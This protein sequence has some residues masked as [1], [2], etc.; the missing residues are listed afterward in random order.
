MS[1]T[2]SIRL[3]PVGII[4]FVLQLSVA[5]SEDPCFNG[6]TLELE[7]LAKRSPSYAL[8]SAPLCD[9][10]ITEA[11]Y[12]TQGYV[13]TIS[14]PSLT[15]CGTLYPVW[16]SET[17]PPDGIMQT[18]T[19]CEVGFSGSCARSY[20]ID[21]KNCTSFLVYK[22]K[23]LDVCNSAYCFELDG[24]CINERVDN[25][26]VSFHNVTWKTTSLSGK[27]QHD[28]Y[29]NLNCSF[30][31]S[32][33]G[34]LL[35]HIDWYVD[36]DI[37]VRGQTVDRTSLQDAILSAEDMIN[38]G[39]KINSWIHCVVGIK[40][41]PHKNPCFSKPSELFFA[42]LEVLDGVLTIERNGKGT[43]R[44]RPT[45]PYASL[46][47]ETENGPFSL[48]LDISLFFPGEENCGA[49]DKIKFR[50]CKTTIDSY[51]YDQRNN[52]INPA[53]WRTIYTLDV[54]N[55]DEEAYYLSHQKS[56]LRL[57]T[58]D[59][60]GGAKIFA[61]ASLHDIE[62]TIVDRDSPWKGKHCHS[63]GD[64]HQLT[65]DGYGYECQARGCVTGKTYILYRNEEFIQEVQ[66][67]HE[68]CGTMPRC[69]CA[70]AARAGQDVFTIDFCNGREI[71]N[72]PLCNENS[73]KVIKLYDKEYKII[74]PSGTYMH[75]S[76]FHM[77][78]AVWYSAVEIYPSESDVSRTS[79]LCGSLDSNKTNDL[80]RRNGTEDNI[81]LFNL[82]N[83]PDE[84]SLSWQ[85]SRGSTEDLL[86]YSQSVFE[87]LK[88]LSSQFHK[89]CT[90][91]AG[92]KIHCNFKQYNECKTKSR[93]KEYHCV[94]HSSGRRK[95]DLKHLT[96]F[97]ENRKE[98][99]KLRRF[100]R[101]IYSEIAA[102]D[103]CNEAFQQSYYY[104]NCLQVVPTFN[105]QSLINCISDVYMTGNPNLTQWNLDTAFR[106][107]QNGIQLNS[108]VQK[109]H[110]E[111]STFIVNLCPN[112]CSNR[113]VCTNGNCTCE[114]GFGGSDCSFDVLSLPTIV[115][116]SDNGICDKSE[117]TCDDI[118]L[119][120]R[121]FLENMG[122]TCYVTREERNEN[123]SVLI[124]TNYSI[125]F[126]ER[127][128]FEGFCSLYYGS[129]PL[130]I[131]KFLFHLSNDGSHFSESYSVYV[132]QSDCQ[133][134]QNDS[135]DIHFTLQMG[136]CFINGTC[137]QDGTFKSDD[138]C[139]Q[140]QPQIDLYEWVRVCNDEVTS[141]RSVVTETRKYPDMEQST[142]ET[143][144]LIVGATFV[145]IITF[146]TV[147]LIYKQC[148]KRQKTDAVYLNHSN[149]Q[150]ELRIYPES[151][152][153]KITKGI[154]NPAY[155]W[156]F[157]SPDEKYSRPSSASS[158]RSLSPTSDLSGLY[159]QQHIDQFFRVNQQKGLKM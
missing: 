13:M 75:V 87:N 58:H 146:V 116:L 48:P 130:W 156:H 15:Y 129:N 43:L 37:V 71:I 104:V 136:Y 12:R 113:G 105:N 17:I 11:W 144:G 119:Y 36:N 1:S 60:S 77:Q 54:F 159:D 57:A 135:G 47:I 120:G 69:V 66:V 132:Y 140:C 25:V 41:L 133:T 9:R 84:F 29:I 134:F 126:E 102:F 4:L 53:N 83:P 122:T 7:H 99:S 61:Y 49:Y 70:V 108:T 68:I 59:A 39:K 27:V 55:S 88:P 92:D 32:D 52:Y 128:L 76:F 44:I 78:T 124:A 64:P 79:G 158:A 63:T 19:A 73:L 94:I 127:T 21:V 16:L 141:E 67:R 23:A 106:E 118:T 157:E 115:R 34:A 93:G 121:Y 123:N 24:D 86:S 85:L 98:T 56:V 81:L 6:N 2:I 3:V 117:E 155:L 89:L 62:L 26:K 51:R 74:F 10:Y 103:I 143:I 100:R 80:R 142:G 95:R 149:E 110:P 137:I 20:E 151:T 8:D 138:T 96:N 147:A 114:S 38:A 97:V 145:S 33:D 72:F 125:G 148:T 18:L 30:T 31:P 131:T 139:L 153:C 111:L 42:G 101:Q 14:P 154:F 90:C 45:I 65:F 22:L 107:C 46:T 109:E 50:K 40:Q 28:P 5:V 152:N 82:N 35:Y 150:N 91:E 112:N